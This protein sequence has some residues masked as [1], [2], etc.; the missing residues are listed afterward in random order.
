MYSIITEV[1][2]TKQDQREY[3]SQVERFEQ[4]EEFAFEAYLDFISKASRAFSL[5]ESRND[6]HFQNSNI[7][8]EELPGRWD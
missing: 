6:I 8:T 4:L 3:G 5:A 1:V 2:Q 7:E